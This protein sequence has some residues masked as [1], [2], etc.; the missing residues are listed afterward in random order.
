VYFPR[1][2]K[3]GNI[4]SACSALLLGRKTKSP[5]VSSSAEP[6][7]TIL[8]RTLYNPGSVYHKQA[9]Y[10]DAIPV[11]RRAIAIQEQVFGSTNPELAR[12]LNNLAESHRCLAQ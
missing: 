5:R 3:F 2:R 8:S 12:M 9:R 11:F 1:P 10:E 4:L 6:N 7:Q